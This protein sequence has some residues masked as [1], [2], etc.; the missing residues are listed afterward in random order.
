[1]TRLRV[2]VEGPWSSTLSAK[3]DN[4]V[5]ASI[6]FKGRLTVPEAGLLVGVVAA[7]ST[8]PNWRTH[9]IVGTLDMDLHAATE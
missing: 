6:A 8:T 1:M 3:F 4:D 9:P 5:S 2:S 7:V